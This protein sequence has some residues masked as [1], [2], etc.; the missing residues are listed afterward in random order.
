MKK[1][2]R[3]TARDND[4]PIGKLTVV[5]DFLPSPEELAKAFPIVKVTLAV[6]A[7]C[8][9]FF[10]NSARQFGGKYQRM[11]RDVLSRYAIHHKPSKRKTRSAPSTT[12]RAAR[13]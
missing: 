6:D 4:M 1:A 13:S 11:M 12:S 5:P 8:L 3:R 9:D 10:K 2:K 7:F